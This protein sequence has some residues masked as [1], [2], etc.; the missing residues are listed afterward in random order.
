MLAELALPT[1]GLVAGDDV[2]ACVCVG[3]G[4]RDTENG[5]MGGGRGRGGVQ[6]Y[7]AASSMEYVLLSTLRLYVAGTRL[8]QPP[9]GT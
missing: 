8:W 5:L 2:V 9:P 7:V 4:V 6:L 3:G 1:V